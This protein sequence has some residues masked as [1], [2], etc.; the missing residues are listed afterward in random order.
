MIRRYRRTIN[1][2][3]GSELTAHEFFFLSCLYKNQP[4]TASA[5]AKRLEVS[6]SYATNVVDK[7]IRKNYVARKRS[8]SDRRIIQLTVTAEGNALYQKLSAVR[9]EYANEM[10]KE[11]NDEELE[12]LSMLLGKLN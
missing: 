6:P 7:L 12:Q 10:F 11:I 2:L 8:E 1:D 5:I 9:R 4:E 3:L